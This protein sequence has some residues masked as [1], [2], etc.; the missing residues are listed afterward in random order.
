[1]QKIFP[2]Y[3]LFIPLLITTIVQSGIYSEIY[4]EV[5][6]SVVVVQANNSQDELIYQGTGFFIDKAG[7]IITNFHIINGSNRVNITTSDGYTYKIKNIIATDLSSDLV[8]LSV[9]IPS[10][11]VHPI[12]MNTIAPEVGEEVSVIG[13][14]EGPGRLAQSMTWG[15]VSSVQ[16]LNEYG[17]VIQI[18]AAVSPGASGSPL[19]NMNREAI[20][21]TTFG[22]IKGQNQNFAVS[23]KQVSKMIQGISLVQNGKP[24]S[25]WNLTS[26][27][28][29]Y[30]NGIDLYR[31]GEYN[32]SL[33]YFKKSIEINPQFS[34]AWNGMGVILYDLGKY[35][36]AIQAFNR[37]IE[38]DPK[39]FAVAWHNKGLA[40]DK[41]GK[42]DEALQAYKRATEISQGNPTEFYREK[43][44]WIE[45][46]GW[47]CPIGLTPEPFSS[48]IPQLPPPAEY[49]RFGLQQESSELE[50]D[51]KSIH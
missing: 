28:V 44:H 27:E 26:E 6:Q 39:F 40:L 20:G 32:Q 34:E 42:Y 17:E 11:L 7:Y 2:L 29:F 10:Q 41:Q 12:K 22:Y 18:D 49:T 50:L 30:G 14:T 5:S 38:I 37:A 1:M 31:K 48:L 4:K 23:C 47:E 13:Y 25:E 9:D 24:I 15:I 3:F 45:G 33:Y 51:G 35:D 46:R 36:E 21:V 16:I 43:C 19:I 8:C